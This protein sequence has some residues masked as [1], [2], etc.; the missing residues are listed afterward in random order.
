M[1][2][3]DE[4]V[5]TLKRLYVLQVPGVLGP[6]LRALRLRRGLTAGTR[7]SLTPRFSSAVC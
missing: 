1:A 2:L 7:L 3:G 5:S 6:I 4:F